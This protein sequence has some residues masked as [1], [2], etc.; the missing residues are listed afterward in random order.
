MRINR[1]LKSLCKT[2]LLIK[3]KITAFFSLL[4]LFFIR[5]YAT[6][7]FFFSLSLPSP[8]AGDSKYGNQGSEVELLFGN[9]HCQNYYEKK[10]FANITGEG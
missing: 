7:Q 3:N 9:P 6:I 2:Q 8:T 1:N 10:R 5:S 4:L